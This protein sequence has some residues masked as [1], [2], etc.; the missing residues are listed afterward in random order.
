MRA[1]SQSFALFLFAVVLGLGCDGF[2]FNVGRPSTVGSTRM[3][4]P[5]SMAAP[6]TFTD[7][8]SPRQLTAQGMDAFR[9]GNVQGSI[10][11]FDQ[12]DAMVPDGSFTPF[13]WQRGLSYYYADRFEDASK[14]A[15]ALCRT[16]FLMTFNSHIRP[17]RCLWSVPN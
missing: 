15:R 2:V 17:F 13:L 5:L 3:L 8:I 10:A 7:G 1:T 14:Q 4:L 12:A 16:S 9:R 11:L 6:M